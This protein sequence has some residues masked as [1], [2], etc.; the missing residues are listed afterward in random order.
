M[1]AVAISQPDVLRPG[2][3]TLL[4]RY[5]RRNQSLVVGLLIVLGLSIF[6]IHGMLTIERP[7]TMSRPTTRL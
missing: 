2:R 5:L 1:T 7:S 6:T 4:L 3:F